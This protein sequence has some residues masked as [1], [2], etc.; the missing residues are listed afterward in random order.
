[1]SITSFNLDAFDPWHCFSKH[2][3]RFLLTLIDSNGVFAEFQHNASC[4]QP[5]RLLENVTFSLTNDIPV[6]T[7]LLKVNEP[8]PAKM[9]NQPF[10]FPLSH[11]YLVSDLSSFCNRKFMTMK[12]VFRTWDVNLF[13]V[14]IPTEFQNTCL[15]VWLDKRRKWPF[16]SEQ[17]ENLFLTV[18][19]LSKINS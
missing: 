9:R 10:F 18:G 15:F 17:L 5:E 11:A 2:I 3:V 4:W 19:F 16:T 14:L 7:S 13:C 12:A 6:L 1:M 8:F